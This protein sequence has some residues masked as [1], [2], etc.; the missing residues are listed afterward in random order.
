MNESWSLAFFLIFVLGMSISVSIQDNAF[1]KLDSEN[2][3]KIKNISLPILTIYIA[4]L[5]FTSALWYCLKHELMPLIYIYT[6]SVLGMVL[7]VSAQ[8]KALQKIKAP[9][10]FQKIWIKSQVLYVLSYSIMWAFI[11]LKK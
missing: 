1:K 11:I 5:L 10:S 4:S 7:I 3:N 2:Q 6:Q 9:I 8:Y